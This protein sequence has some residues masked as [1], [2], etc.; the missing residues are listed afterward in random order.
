MSFGSSQNKSNQ[1]EQQQNGGGFTDA[2]R[3]TLADEYSAGR[4]AET[5]QTKE[6]IQAQEIPS[7]SATIRMRSQFVNQLQGPEDNTTPVVLSHSI[8]PGLVKIAKNNT[9]SLSSHRSNVSFGKQ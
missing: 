8:K 4:N 9:S 2:Y 1:R 6:S 3:L 5:V 7:P